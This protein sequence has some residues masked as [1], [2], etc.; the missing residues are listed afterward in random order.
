MQVRNHSDTPM[1]TQCDGH[2]QKKKKQKQKEVLAK[3][4]RNG[5]LVRRGWEG[6][7]VQQGLPWG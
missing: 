3:T 5:M 4:Q 2:S 1:H 6:K 7:M